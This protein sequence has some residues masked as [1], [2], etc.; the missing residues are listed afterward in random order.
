[1]KVLG[2][3]LILTFDMDSTPPMPTIS[4]FHLIHKRGESFTLSADM[5]RAFNKAVNDGLKK[6]PNNPEVIFED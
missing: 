5:I 3:S 6:L 2:V 4:E 1:M